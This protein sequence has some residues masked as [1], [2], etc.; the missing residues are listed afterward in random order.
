LSAGGVLSPLLWSLFVDGLLRELNEGGY[1]AIGYADY[2]A[3][4]IN[5]KFP[6]TVSEVLQTALGLV[7]LQ[8]C[9]RT[10]LSINPSKTV[11]IPFT[12]KRVLK[13]LKEL[14]LFGKTIQLFADVRY[15]GLTSDKGLT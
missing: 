11:I 12:K 14:T 2:I 13:D 3:I 4:L 8:W 5:G 6:Q 15:L 7:V 1:Y 10:G 9:D